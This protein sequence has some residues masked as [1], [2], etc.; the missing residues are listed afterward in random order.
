MSSTSKSIYR[1]AIRRLTYYKELGDRTFLQL[2]DADLYYRPN[3]ESNSIAMI[4]RH[5]AG[6]MLSRWTDFLT[7]DGEKE[8]RNRNAEF[9]DIR[10]SR[11]EL[12]Q[13]WE[14]G[15]NCLFTTLGRLKKKHLKRTIRI[16]NEEMTV[17]DA[18]HRQLAHYPYHI[19]QIVY[20]G[21]LLRDRNWTNLSIPRAADPP[22]SGDPAAN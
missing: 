13:L 10:Q 12:L 11:E 4:I 14:N 21:K 2:Q 17:V 22:A 9:E 16:R 15:W 3:E 20:I 6:N 8:W 19:G 5:L 7:T 18:I 1:S